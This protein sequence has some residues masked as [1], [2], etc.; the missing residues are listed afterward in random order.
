MSN[1][2]DPDE[3]AHYETDP[4]ETAHYEPSHLELCCLQNPMAVKELIK[5]AVYVIS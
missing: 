4:D 3:T 2:L 5:Y 1:S